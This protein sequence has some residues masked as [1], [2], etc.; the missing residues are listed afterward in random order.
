[1]KAHNQI[2]YIDMKK[3]IEL[4]MDVL[5]MAYNAIA[6]SFARAFFLDSEQYDLAIFNLSNLCKK[7]EAFNCKLNIDYAS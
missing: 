3:P 7:I 5:A 4:M 6:Y 1:M 2:S